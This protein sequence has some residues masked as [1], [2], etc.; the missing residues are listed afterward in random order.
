MYRVGEVA[1]IA[2]LTPGL[3]TLYKSHSLWISCA[4]QAVDYMHIKKKKFKS[5]NLVKESH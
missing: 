3:C 5:L 2:S 4:F 1:A